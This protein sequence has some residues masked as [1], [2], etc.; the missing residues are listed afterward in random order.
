[1][2]VSRIE[3]YNPN[4]INWR[5]LTAKEILKYQKQGVEVPDVYVQWAHEF[6][7]NLQ[8]YDNDDVT[9]EKARSVER[10]E[11]SELNT[12]KNVTSDNTL[13]PDSDHNSVTGEPLDETIQPEPVLNN[14]TDSR[15]NEELTAA[16]LKRKDLQDNGV[17]LRDQ[18]G[19]FT[20][21][22]IIAGQQ[23]N[24]SGIMMGEI[25]SSSDN[26][27]SELEGSM[28]ELIAQAEAK[29]NELKQNV[30]KI[31]Q[32]KNTSSAFAKIEQ[33]QKELEQ[34]GLSGHNEISLAR[35][36]FSGYDGEIGAGQEIMLNGA[37]FGSE[38]V[39]IGNELIATTGNAWWFNKDRII[40]EKAVSAGT[41]AVDI[42][43][44][45][46]DAVRSADVVNKANIGKVP[47]LENSVTSKT[48][49]DA[50]ES[51]E[52]GNSEGKD[53]ITG[54]EKESDKDLKTAEND[55]TDTTDKLH[56]SIDE[57][58]KRKVRRGEYSQGA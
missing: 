57:L 49:V 39:D 46:E 52:Q 26:E 43:Q 44:Q 19:L 28:K 29:Q 5:N 21:D 17:E 2:D 32:D 35:S 24:A 23:A 30:D 48:G 56:I 27:I 41:D 13:L 1:M 8:K 54:K 11:N 36:L 33:L 6:L 47:E 58:L 51:K 42:S 40:G 20:Q 50:K 37:D 9:Y 14:N 15:E 3:A 31:N 4:K 7:N 18:A 34:F 45:G 38:T 53:P 25:Q 22:S 55:G 12:N 10:H 16:Q